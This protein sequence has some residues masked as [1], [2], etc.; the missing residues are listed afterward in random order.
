MSS[1][2]E[3]EQ[4]VKETLHIASGVGIRVTAADGSAVHGRTKVE[5]SGLKLL[6]K[7]ASAGNM[8]VATFCDRYAR[9]IG[10]Q[11]GAHVSLTFVDTQISGNIA[12]KNLSP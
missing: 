2:S 5:T 10:A 9:C 6:V 7:D 8:R 4:Y 11:V 3:V 12:L 1:L